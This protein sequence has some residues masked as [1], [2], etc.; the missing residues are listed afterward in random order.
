MGGDVFHGGQAV[1]GQLQYEGSGFSGKEGVLEE[2]AGKNA[3]QHADD[4]QAKDH[5][6]CPGAEERSGDH[7]V[8]RQL[9]GTGHE[10]DEQDG[11]TSVLLIFHGPRA[12]NGGH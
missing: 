3:Y 6:T 5:Q 2:D 7:A 1:G 12:H 11:H 9:G 10:G 4:I 8:Y